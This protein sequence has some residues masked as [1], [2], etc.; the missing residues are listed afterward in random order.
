M[1]G[2]KVIN[3]NDLLKDQERILKPLEE[4]IKVIV[5]DIHGGVLAI[6]GE[7]FHGIAL[8]V[9]EA[10]MDAE[11]SQIAGVKGISAAFQVPH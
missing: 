10:V 7:K 5:T 8:E 1:R 6:L 11:I 3:R 9:M 2:S 4:R